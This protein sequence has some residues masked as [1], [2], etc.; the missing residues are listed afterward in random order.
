[1][2]ISLYDISV[3][4]Y[5]QIVPAVTKLLEKAV[6]HFATEGVEPDDINR[7]RLHESMLPMRFQLASVAHHSIGTIAAMR[8]GVFS[9][10]DYDH[11]LDFAAMQAKLEQARSELAALQRDEINAL[12]GKPMQ[13]VMGDLKLP[14]TTDT[15]VLSFS[16]PNFYFHAT[17]AY[18]ILRHKGLP[19]EKR[20]FLGRLNYIREPKA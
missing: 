10:P 11:K 13:F 16:L 14:F 7:W 19:L 1:V 4:S 8:S 9:P 5:L 3:A 6:A 17:T 20:D 18:D 12:S 15:F 2:S